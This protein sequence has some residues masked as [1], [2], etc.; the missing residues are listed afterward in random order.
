MTVHGCQTSSWGGLCF[1]PSVLRMSYL[2]AIMRGIAGRPTGPYDKC[3]SRGFNHISSSALGTNPNTLDLTLFGQVTQRIRFPDR[4]QRCMKGGPP[5]RR[6]LSSDA[7]CVSPTIL[8]LKGKYANVNPVSSWVRSMNS[9]GI[10]GRKKRKIT[11][12][13]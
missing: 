3:H 12:T 5:Q 10:C 7:Q 4:V 9:G 8:V 13:Q 6:I 11:E 1:G 2:L